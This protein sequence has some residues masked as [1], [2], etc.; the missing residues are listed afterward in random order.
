MCVF[1]FFPSLADTYSDGLGNLDFE[2]SQL[3][4]GMSQRGAAKRL[5]NALHLHAQRTNQKQF[6]LQML[7]S[8]ADKLNIKV[9]TFRCTKMHKDYL[10]TDTFSLSVCKKLA[11]SVII[12]WICD[13]GQF[14]LMKQG[15]SKLP[16][17]IF[18]TCFNKTVEI[19]INFIHVGST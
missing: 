19:M 3:G 16:E 18:F 7:R 2:R 17:L 4:S 15:G 6:D 11:T 14:L 5:V 13:L 8:V 9:N 12:N 1:S 10:K